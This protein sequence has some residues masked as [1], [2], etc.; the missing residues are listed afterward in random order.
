MRRL[1]ELAAGYSG[2]TVLVTGGFGFLGLNL[3]ERLREGGAD[4]RVL[5]RSWPPE[6]RYAPVTEGVRFY[7]ADIRDEVMVE[8]AVADADVIFNLAGKS[9]ASASNSSPLDDL[10]V[11]ARGQLVLL[12]ACRRLNPAVRIVF[13]SS[14]LVYRPA[15]P[16][17]VSEN[18][19]VG[20]CSIY[21]VHKLTGEQYHQLYARLYGL[22]AVILRITN[23]YGPFQRR[24][25]NRYGIINW[26]IHLAM[27][28]KP[29]PVYGEGEQLRDYVHADDV[30]RAFLLAGNGTHAERIYN[31]GGGTGVSFREM[32][33]KIVR[34]TGG[35]GIES[36]PWPED[37][38]RI[39]SGSFVAD[40]SRIREE[41]GWIPG[42]SLD[43]GLSDVVS[44]LREFGNR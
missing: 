30:I 13:P 11:N 16:L 19:P 38:A 34:L 21:G 25:Q 36:V 27:S 6:G 39:E 17:P 8:Q 2:R 44:R 5:A 14:R 1:A 9:G 33:E 12:E 7:K 26:F 29:L 4:I 37:A 35:P 24:E 41:M 40:V 10:D 31:V 28:G 43:D 3:I 18:A 22:N 20:P 23:P 42:I 32:A 15:L